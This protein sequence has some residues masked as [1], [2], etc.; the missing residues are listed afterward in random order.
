MTPNLLPFD[1]SD[2]SLSSGPKSEASNEKDS[3]THRMNDTELFIQKTFESDPEKGCECLFRLYYRALCTHAVRFVY[4]KEV[5]EDIV[6]EVFYTFW[7]TQAYRSVKTSY[8]AYLFR[9]VRNRSYNYLS[10]DL[11]KSDP[12][13]AAGQPEIPESESPDRIMQLDELMT[14]INQLVA[15][16]PPQCQK[17][18]VMN[19]FEGRKSKEIAE[20]LQLSPRTVEA[21]LFKAMSLLKNGLKNQ[22]PWIVLLLV[23]Y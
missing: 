17:V 8:R 10:N 5:A 11:R 14:T 16:L 23:F 15:S 6:S 20:E 7:N 1:N 3:E 4:S 9:S 22:W 13:T 19:R 18:F 21:H 2:R 12:L